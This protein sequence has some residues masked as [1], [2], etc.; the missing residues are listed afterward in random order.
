MVRPL[1]ILGPTA[2]GKSDLALQLARRLAATEARP[3]EIISADS[4]QIYRRL[5]AGTAKPTPEERAEIKHH[6]IDC[7]EPTEPFTVAQWL[8][9]ADQAILTLTAKGVRPIIV[10]G[11]NFYLRA[12]LEG[13][14]AGPGSDEQIRQQLGTQTNQQLA[15]QLARVD[16]EAAAR[17]HPNDRKRLIRALEVFHLTGQPISSLQSQWSPP[18]PPNPPNPPNPPESP[19]SPG[20][21][22]PRQSAEQPKGTDLSAPSSGPAEA[23][24]ASPPQPERPANRSR[25]DIASSAAAVVRP[26]R[27]HPILIGLRWSAERINPRINQR[28]RQMFDPPPGRTW[29]ALNLPE[30]TRLL[31]AAG[32]L[33]PQ[34]REALGY[35]QVLAALAGRCSMAE[36][37][38]QTKI[39]TRRFAKQQ[40][41]WL[42]RFF[43]VWWIDAD[44]TDPDRRPEAVIRQIEQIERGDRS[45][46]GPAGEL[47]TC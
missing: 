11:T 47:L 7:V 10:G 30:E 6:L 2:G 22:K 16:P 20:G 36:A 45:D 29:P 32:L 28:V 37:M 33:G 3:P 23:G 12:L 5:D 4:M 17:I 9:S 21:R 15:D 19:E 39:L 34:A 8:Q 13:F 14:F 35:K 42:K 38:E 31:E 26:Y 44:Q 46:P 25:Q 1:V 41:T 18:E 27:H 43:G 40:R 24:R